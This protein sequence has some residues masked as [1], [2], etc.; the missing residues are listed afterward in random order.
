MEKYFMQ[1]AM[2][3][4]EFTGNQSY[5]QLAAKAANKC[6]NFSLDDDDECVAE[7]TVSCLNCRYRKWTQRS[8]VCLKMNKHH[9][10]CL[11][12]KKIYDQP[13]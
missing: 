12:T 9:L 2:S 8:F 4:W 10:L 1:N 7:E 13:S 5:F 11:E 6:S 3:E